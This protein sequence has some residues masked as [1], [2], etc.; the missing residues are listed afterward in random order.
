MEKR[1]YQLLLE[2]M[3]TK[4]L[5]GNE[6]A[7]KLKI[8]SRSIRTMIKD[9][10]YDMEQHGAFIESSKS[11]GYSLCITNQQS[12]LL[13]M[14]QESGTCE[15][16]SDP[17]DRLQFL[18][19]T[20]IQSEE[21]FKLDD[22][23]EELCLSRTQLK[24]SMKL[25]RTYF[26]TYELQL[27]ARPHAG[28]R[29]VGSEVKKRQC[30]AHFRIDH[31]EGSYLS[32]LETEQE[33]IEK[34]TNIVSSCIQNA[35]YCIS[36]DAFH[37]LIVHLFIAMKR[38]QKRQYVP[39]DTEMLEKLKQEQ[40]FMIATTIL[41]LMSQLFHIPY[42]ENE[43]GYITIHLLGKK[44]NTTGGMI[45]SDEITSLVQQVLQKIKAVDQIQFMNDFHLQLALSSHL[46]V[47]KNRIEYQMYMKNPLLDDIKCSIFHSYEIAIH[48][49]EVINEHFHCTL[50]ED[51]IAYF[52]L[53]FNL[54][55]ERSFHEITKLNILIVC[56]SGAG[57]AQLL[58]YKFLEQFSSYIQRLEVCS[59]IDLKKQ[60]AKGFDYVFT[61]IPIEVE[62][63]I[64][65]VSIHHFLD[66]QDITL[67]KKN[68]TQSHHSSVATYFDERLFFSCEKFN[69][70]EE[71][72]HF[73]VEQC[74]QYYDL[75]NDYEQQVLEREKIAST[76][77]QSYVAF[78]HASKLVS[79]QTFV[80][81][82]VLKKSLLWNTD[83]VRIVL[84]AS[85]EKGT[86]KQ[87]T[88]FYKVMSKLMRSEQAQG[89]LME[90]PTYETLKELL[91][92][93]ECL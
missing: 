8:S 9:I 31:Q 36:D 3:N 75:P 54:A 67:I 35:E 85:I 83:K 42:E 77:F 39:M 19:Q 91:E 7:L 4:C 65:V 62:D 10:N 34:L 81:V 23:C 60:G 16:L 82:M 89:K 13:F 43:C 92:E 26:E 40:E 72:I 38:I 41:T 27:E 50:P 90:K 6:L 59:A 86:N 68:L 52:A 49:A 51:E 74:H 71:V 17:Q 73:L 48:A 70:K 87:L 37:N 28:V 30:I 45:I 53:H 61:T 66:E 80:A 58:K 12:F 46:A 47:L 33:T 24:Q 69:N 20:F 29:L 25:L 18:F 56:S 88:T 63:G 11:S 32:S 5:T 79:D 14:Q 57:S 93:L 22:L 1:Q 76:Q 64:P 21:F 78:P 2:L 15:D 84:L 55:M 44:L